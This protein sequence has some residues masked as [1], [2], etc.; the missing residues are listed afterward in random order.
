MSHSSSRI[1]KKMDLKWLKVGQIPAKADAGKQEEFLNE[2]LN[3]RI[4]DAKKGE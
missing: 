1:P 2:K 3:P 4:E